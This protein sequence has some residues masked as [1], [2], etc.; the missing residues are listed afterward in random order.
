MTRTAGGN[1]I[2]PGTI[3]EWQEGR[4]KPIRWE[5]IG[6][7]LGAL[8]QESLIEMKCLTHKPGHIPHVVPSPF[9]MVHVFVPEPLTRNLRI[10]DEVQP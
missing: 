5:V 6:V 10:V 1:P 2:G 3:L 9:A 4:A 7:H 8:G